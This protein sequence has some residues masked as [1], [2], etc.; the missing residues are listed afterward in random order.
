MKLIENATKLNGRDC[1]QFV[2]KQSAKNIKNWIR[3]KNG[4][5]CY[6]YVGRLWAAGEQD[7][8]LEIPGCIYPNIVAHELVHVLGYG[9]Q[10][11]KFFYYWLK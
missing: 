2:D 8:S 5:G 1:I 4:N 7:V 11:L 10:N 9:S 3:I 6:S